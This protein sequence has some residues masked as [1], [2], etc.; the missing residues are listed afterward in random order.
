MK[1]YKDNKPTYDFLD[2]IKTTLSIQMQL[3]LLAFVCYNH[4]VYYAMRIRQK[5]DWQ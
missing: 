4:V 5:L 3:Q 2:S 1:L